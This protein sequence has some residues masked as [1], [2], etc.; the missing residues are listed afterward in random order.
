MVVAVPFLIFVTCVIV[1]I[2]AVTW[3]CRRRL[4]VTLRFS[5]VLLTL[6]VWDARAYLADRSVASRND[7]PFATFTESDWQTITRHRVLLFWI[8]LASVGPAGVL[9]LSLAIRPG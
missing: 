6:L 8:I 5:T 2:A 3:F 9:V 7:W 1:G 4:S